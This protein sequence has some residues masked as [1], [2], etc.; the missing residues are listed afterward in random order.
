MKGVYSWCT[1]SRR[2]LLP[3]K[4]GETNEWTVTVC[5][6]RDDRAAEGGDTRKDVRTLVTPSNG[7]CEKQ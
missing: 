4:P 5:K 7:G 2:C 6:P 3:P 1:A